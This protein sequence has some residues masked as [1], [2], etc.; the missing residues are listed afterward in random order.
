MFLQLDD[1]TYEYFDPNSSKKSPNKYAKK[2]FIEGFPMQKQKTVNTS[3]QLQ[4]VHSPVSASPFSIKRDGDY[5]QEQPL[6][7]KIDEMQQL[8]DDDK[9]E[10]NKVAARRLRDKKRK[11]SQEQ[12]SELIHWTKKVEE[13]GKLCAR[14]EKEIEE[15]R[16]KLRNSTIILN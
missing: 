8:K 2:P 10:R 7:E 6:N 9:R 14:L 5:H 11:E 16:A 1:D 12:T 13:N 15:L 4:S 3:F